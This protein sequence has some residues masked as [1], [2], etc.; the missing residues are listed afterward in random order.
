MKRQKNTG[1]VEMVESKDRR[2]DI[3]VMWIMGFLMF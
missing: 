2:K 3:F 1:N